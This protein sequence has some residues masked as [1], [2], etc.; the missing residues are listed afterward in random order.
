[1]TLEQYC[2]LA[3]V[4][5]KLCCLPSMCLNYIAQIV[6]AKWSF[7]SLSDVETG[8]QELVISSSVIVCLHPSGSLNNEKIC[9]KL[10][11]K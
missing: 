8:S 4:V 9:H 5:D 6:Q 7:V 10:V 11:I 2:Y 1:M 3:K